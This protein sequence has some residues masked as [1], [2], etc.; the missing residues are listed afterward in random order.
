MSKLIDL[1]GNRF[2]M[3]K[4]IQ[5]SP[6]KRNGQVM[7]DCLCDCGKYV[8]VRGISLRNGDTKSCGCRRAEKMRK[9]KTKHGAYYNR[10]K[11]E[12][13]YNIYNDMK[14]R[15]YNPK[16]KSYPDYGGLGIYICDEWLSSYEAFRTWAMSNGYRD[17]LTIDRINNDGPYR[18]ENCRWATWSQQNKN[19]RKFYS[20]KRTG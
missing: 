9:E 12:R 3:L 10:T 18:P 1:T 14:Y 20:G 17:D 7:W 5:K 11:R 15:C 19:R 2:G 4:V 8:V 6:Q 13:L 16:A